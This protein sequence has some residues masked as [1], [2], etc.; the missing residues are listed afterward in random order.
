MSRKK[1]IPAVMVTS[2]TEA[3]KVLEELA[4]LERQANSIKNTMNEKI[5][6]AKAQATADM[7][8]VA[9]RVKILEAALSG[10]ALANKSSLFK[11]KKSLDLD[12]GT[13]SFRQ[14]SKIVTAGKGVTWD[15]VLEKLKDG[16][17][18]EGIRISEEV[19]K[20]ALARWDDA[21]L[22]KVGAKRKTADTFGYD[23]KQ[24]EPGLNQTQAA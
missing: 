24:Q 14:S 15:M 16:G 2:L 13:L 4:A 3:D 5:D 10:Y 8:E 12:F 7:V 23:L 17:F 11:E 9:T 1:P 21:K 22:E 20:E 18:T 19:N 6:Q